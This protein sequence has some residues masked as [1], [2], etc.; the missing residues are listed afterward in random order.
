V[1]ALRKLLAKTNPELLKAILGKTDADQLDLE[2]LKK[3]IE[4][5]LKEIE[6]APWPPPGKV[7]SRNDSWKDNKE[8]PLS[9][10]RNDAE[11]G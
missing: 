1:P 5:A 3:T 10:W 9:S 8:D 6:K 7:G 2:T 4:A 11:E